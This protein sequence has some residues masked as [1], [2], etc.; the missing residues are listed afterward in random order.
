MRFRTLGAKTR[1]SLDL[2]YSI[3]AN[4]HKMLA[5]RSARTG[6]DHITKGFTRY[7][8]VRSNGFR[9]SV[10]NINHKNYNIYIYVQY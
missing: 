1:Q 2:E 9:G 3:H 8:S 5:M 6:L 7:I 10:F 4:K